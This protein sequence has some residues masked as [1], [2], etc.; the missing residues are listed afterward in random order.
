MF[1]QYN[2]SG[3]RLKSIC[4]KCTCIMPI[5]FNTHTCVYAHTHTHTQT[6]THTYTHTTTHTHTH[7][8]TCVCVSYLACRRHAQG[9]PPGHEYGA[10]GHRM[11]SCGSTFPLCEGVSLHR[12]VLPNTYRNTLRCQWCVSSRSCVTHGGA[13]MEH[14]S[15]L[16]V[17]FTESLQ[18][19]A[20]ATVG[21]CQG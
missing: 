14:M 12:R 4:R 17:R 7:T 6:H 20:A 9:P 10:L 2:M 1:N 11:S 19:M 18:M 15:H 3:A 8:Y 21:I 16:R 13:G 5:A